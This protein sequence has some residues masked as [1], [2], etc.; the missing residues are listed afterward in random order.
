M[1]ASET[2]LSQFCGLPNLPCLLVSA[3]VLSRA[4]HFSAVSLNFSVK[5]ASADLGGCVQSHSRVQPGSLEGCLD[6]LK[7]V[8]NGYF[9]TQF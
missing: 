8:A 1:S 3:V 2:P 4:T 9:P 7:P 5:L 6:E